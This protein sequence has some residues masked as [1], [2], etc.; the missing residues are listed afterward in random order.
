MKRK[1]IWRI[2]GRAIASL[3]LGGAMVTSLCLLLP[4][5]AAQGA[6]SSSFIPAATAAAFKEITGLTALS[7]PATMAQLGSR[8]AQYVATPKSILEKTPVTV[9]A[10]KGKKIALLICGVPVCAEFG[11]A[12]TQAAHLLGWKVI[13]IPL[14]TDPQQFTD[15]YNTAIQDKPNMV[16]GSGLPRSFFNSQLLQLQKMKIPVIEWSSGI[17]PVP[18]HIWVTAD[19]PLYQAAGIMMAEYLSYYSNLKAQVLELSSVQYTMSSLF[20]N[21]LN[22]YGPSICPTC[23]FTLEEEPVTD[24]G[25][26]GP[27]ADLC[28][29]VGEALK[30]AGFGSVKVITRDSGTL[31]FENMQLGLE[32]AAMPLPIYETGYQI[33]DLAQRIFNHQSTANTRLS[34]EQIV[35]T[36]SN[37]NSTTIGAD[38]NFKTHYKKLWKLIK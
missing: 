32:S 12:A 29:G 18:G 1:T 28:Q 7:A 15:A 13:D 6:G 27:I 35:T 33:I 4:E 19:N 24:I 17:T 31:N 5:S 36:M 23:K 11:Q 34:P 22:Q 26:A 30:V 38:P 2:R 9:K 25:S 37:P 14:G 3:A 20:V 21:T 8:V 16:V 10:T